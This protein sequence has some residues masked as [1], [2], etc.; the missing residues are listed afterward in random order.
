VCAA[1][2]SATE[3]AYVAGDILV[4]LTAAGDYEVSRVSGNGRST[5]VMGV[6]TSQPAALAMADRATSGY[7]RVF[8]RADLSS[9]T[10]RLVTEESTRG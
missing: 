1:P 5:H 2:S 7:Q 8:L 10:Y 6:R 3:P 9:M 4:A